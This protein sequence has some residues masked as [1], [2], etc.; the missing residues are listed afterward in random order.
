M[1]AGRVYDT[2]GGFRGMTDGRLHLIPSTRRALL[3]AACRMGGICGGATPEQ[4]GASPAMVKPWASCSRSSMICWM[5][6]NPPNIGKATGKDVS[7]G[8][9]TFPGLLKFRVRGRKSP[10]CKRRRT[11][12]LGICAPRPLQILCDIMAIRTK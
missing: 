4:L 5:S 12:S 1:I 3:R 11:G 8:K 9:L 10:E 6:R 7:A 2:L